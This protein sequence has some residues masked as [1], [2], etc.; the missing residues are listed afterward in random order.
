MSGQTDLHVTPIRPLA[1]G[2][3]GRRR[4][5]F[6]DIGYEGEADHRTGG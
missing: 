6:Q 3:L 5:F 2:A 4:G 1:E